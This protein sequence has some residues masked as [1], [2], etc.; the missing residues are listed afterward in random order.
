MLSMLRNREFRLLFSGQAISYIGDQFH[1]IALPWLVL[2]L[3]NDP[4]QLG[5]VLAVAGIPRALLM[6]VGGAW[7][8]RYSPRKIMLFSDAL[9]FVVTAAL[10]AAILTGNAEVWM[11]YVLAGVFGTVSGFFMP[12]A[13][14]TLPRV[15]Q[16][17]QLEGGNALM[18]GANQLANFVGPVAAGL[19]IA[20]SGAGSAAVA[21]Q[22]A[23]LYGIG[24][25]FAVDAA[26]FL[27]SAVAVLMMRPI[28]P[29]NTHRDSHPLTDVIEGLRYSLGS[30]HLRAM[31]VI[32]GSA[33][34]LVAGPM[35]VGMPVLAQTRLGGATAFGMVMSAYAIGS[36]GGMVIAG[37]LPRPNDRLFGWLVAGLLGGFG[38]SMA[39]LGY[40]TSV[41]AVVALM[42]VTGAGNGF[43]GVHA[44][45]SVQRMSD[46]RYLGRLMSL[47]TLAMVGLMPISQ[48]L[49]GAVIRV[50]PEVLFVGAGVGFAAL[51][52]WSVTQRDV[53]EFGDARKVPGETSA[54][55]ASA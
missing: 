5:G 31:L 15:V 51:A 20:A 14:A 23:S 38:V 9:R 16:A 10:A 35:F 2:T 19:L 40:L 39:L 53:W 37:A 7:A 4:M 46:E 28:R 54:V 24:I 22:T 49:A 17:E 30:N 44:I 52:A 48:A 50:S 12:A 41:W 29:A 1:L 36:L 34:F 33:N 43:I 26:S 25:A 32:I 6:L 18:M 21:E 13:Q 8:D 45:T 47:I 27:A 42:V 55:P 11:V 3:T